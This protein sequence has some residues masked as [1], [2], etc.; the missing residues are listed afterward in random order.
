VLDANDGARLVVRLARGDADALSGRFF[1]ALDDL[2]DVLR[3]RD[4]VEAQ[5]L[6]VP[7]LR[8]L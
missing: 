7:R 8:R 3:R 5:D 2:D 1:H 6:Y 4:E